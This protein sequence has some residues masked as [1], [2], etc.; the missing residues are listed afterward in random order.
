MSRGLAPTRSGRPSA[1]GATTRDR[2]CP[3]P[4]PGT[5]ASSDIAAASFPA[6][7]TATRG[8]TPPPAVA[9]GL[10]P[11]ARGRG[12]RGSRAG[13]ALAAST[14]GVS[15]RLPSLASSPAPAG[16]SPSWGAWEPAVRGRS[17]GPTT[18]AGLAIPRQ[19][20]PLT[21]P[22]R[23]FCS[24][25]HCS[26]WRAARRS[27]AGESPRSGVGWVVGVSRAHPRPRGLAVRPRHLQ[28]QPQHAS[29]RLRFPG[30]LQRRLPWL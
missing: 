17:V 26:R 16:I 9:A 8:D 20:V 10:A 18:V 30:G 25:G 29:S 7:I 1:T 14:S 5:G 2:R 22:C 19:A 3:Q 21:A 6:P 15:P 27:V 12:S 23:G 28:H 13:P 24:N 4:R 11:S